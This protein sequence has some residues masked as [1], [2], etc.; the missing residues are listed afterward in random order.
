[1]DWVVIPRL[2]RAAGVADVSNFGGLAKQFAVTFKPAELERYGL[3]LG[4]VIDALKSNNASGGGS[5]LNRG[6]MSFVIRGRGSLQN[7]EQIRNIFIKSV[8]GTPIYLRDVATVGLDY[9]TP[10]GI[11]SKDRTDESVEGI[12]LMRRGEN[13]S[14]VLRN[15]KE[16]VEELNGP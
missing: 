1:N 2:L 16:V 4:D 12:V 8:D 9:Q 5:V 7:E 6:S 11:Y 14:A 3:A 10:S 13:P 15:V